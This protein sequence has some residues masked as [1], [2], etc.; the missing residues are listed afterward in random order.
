VFYSSFTAE[1]IATVLRRELDRKPEGWDAYAKACCAYFDNWSDA[2]DW[3]AG[4]SELL[5]DAA[6]KARPSHGH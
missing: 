1:D 4:Q 3:D 2:G 5:F 6:L